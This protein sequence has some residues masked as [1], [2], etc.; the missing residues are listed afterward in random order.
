[1]TVAQ[2]IAPIKTLMDQVQDLQR[3]N[4]LSMPAG[5][6][7]GAASF[8]L[9][10]SQQQWKGMKLFVV[11]PW[12]LSLRLPLPSTQDIL[13]QPWLKVPSSWIEHGKRKNDGTLAKLLSWQGLS[14]HLIRRDECSMHQ[15]CMCTVSEICLLYS[16]R[17]HVNLRWCVAFALRRH[18]FI[19]GTCDS[20]F[21]HLQL[22]WTCGMVMER[23]ERFVLYYV[24]LVGKF[25]DPKIPN[26]QAKPTSLQL[27]I[28]E[29]TS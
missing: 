13:T 29:L 12:I 24:S 4:Q 6:A 19:P 16:L 25:V 26:H 9:L 14:V 2:T 22:S 20:V 18:H 17:W 27:T 7:L 21:S 10:F 11:T 3:Q 23:R 15:S 5:T 28:S 8:L 1:M